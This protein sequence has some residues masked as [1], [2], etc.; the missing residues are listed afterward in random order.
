M[1]YSSLAGVFTVIVFRV[2]QRWKLPLFLA[3]E[4]LCQVLG[5]VLA[6]VFAYPRAV[7]DGP[8]LRQSFRY[9]AHLCHNRWEAERR[10]TRNRFYV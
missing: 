1:K 9:E 3:Q 10:R 4:Q 7:H 5:T 2:G 8:S 6:K